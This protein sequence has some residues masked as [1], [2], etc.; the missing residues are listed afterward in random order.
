[1]KFSSWLIGGMVARRA[2]IGV[3]QHD[4]GAEREEDLTED[5]LRPEELV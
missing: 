5:A 2:P 3:A 4:R 1:M